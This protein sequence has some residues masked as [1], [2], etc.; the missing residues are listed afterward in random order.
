MESELKNSPSDSVKIEKLRVLITDDEVGIRLGIRRAIQRL[1]IPVPEVDYRIG[2]EIDEAE[3]G[4]EAIEKIET[5]RPDILLLDHKLPDISGLE[6]LDY[7]SENGIDLLTV[8]ITAY[9]SLETAVT[10]TERGAY[11]FL[12]KPFT[13]DALNGAVRKA[14]TRVVLAKEVRRLKKELDQT[15]P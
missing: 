8:M 3:T 14:A 2:F 7:L 5:T 4:K 10:A 9:A 12:A 15:A 11:D 6:I 13:P 1:V